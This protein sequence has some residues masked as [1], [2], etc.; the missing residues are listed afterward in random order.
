MVTKGEEREPAVRLH[1]NGLVGSYQVSWPGG[2]TTGLTYGGA[3]ECAKRW[4]TKLGLPF[5]DESKGG[6]PG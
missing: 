3:L 6:M 1:T 4:A 5:I 2:G